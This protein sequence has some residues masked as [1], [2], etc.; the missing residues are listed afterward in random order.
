MGKV[1]AL[2]AAAGPIGASDALRAQHNLAGFD[3]SE[4]TL[5]EWLRRRAMASQTRGAAR[6]YVVC[7]A[8]NVAVGY[9]CLAAGALV[10]DE[11]TSALRWNMPDPIP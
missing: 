5:D 9:Y 4:P 3:G 1:V 8:G 11:A 10:R 7:E 2:P 6:T